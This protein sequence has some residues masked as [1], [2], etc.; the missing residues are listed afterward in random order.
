MRNQFER[1]RKRLAQEWA[2]KAELDRQIKETIVQCLAGGV[3][4]TEL[5]DQL[6]EFCREEG[7]EMEPLTMEEVRT[8]PGYVETVTIYANN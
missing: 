8:W 7:I 2:E 3:H 1:I 5:N 4:L 6:T